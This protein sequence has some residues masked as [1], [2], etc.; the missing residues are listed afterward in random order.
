MLPLPLPSF[1]FNTF[2]FSLKSKQKNKKLS[3][4]EWVSYMPV[5]VFNY[6]FF[7]FNVDLSPFKAK[8][9]KNMTMFNLLIW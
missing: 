6:N 9:V 8:R 3:P 2:K 4:Y 7:L 1:I 5:S